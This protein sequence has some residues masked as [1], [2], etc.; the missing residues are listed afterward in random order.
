MDKQQSLPT[1]Q[2][3]NKPAPGWV[4]LVIAA[5]GILFR[6]LLQWLGI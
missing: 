2:V 1:D 3:D 5:L 4:W 6:L